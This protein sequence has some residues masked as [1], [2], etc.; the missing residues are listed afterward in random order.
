LKLLL[1]GEGLDSSNA[2]LMALLAEAQ[3]VVGEQVLLLGRR[4]D[5]PALMPIL[6]L[7]VLAS[8]AEGFPNVVAEA[9]ACEVPNVVTNVGDAAFIVGE[10]GW[11]V[12]PQDA[13][14]LA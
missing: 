12:P 5:V 14:A 3:L 9:M 13:A 7:H 11:V 10:V 1:I 6:D 4:D 8:L 2:E